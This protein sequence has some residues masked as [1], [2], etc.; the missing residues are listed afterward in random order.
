HWGTGRWSRFHWDLP[1]YGQ[2]KFG[3]GAKASALIQPPVLA[4]AV[5][6]V[7][8][9]SQD[10]DFLRETL[11][12]VRRYYL[13]LHDQRDPDGDGLISVISPYETGM[14]QLP[15]YDRVLGAKNPSSLEM[16]FRDRL[17]DLNNLVLGRN[18]NLDAI[19]RRDA[20]NVEDVM[21]NCIYAQGLRD[22]SELCA[23]AGDETAA[24]GFRNMAGRVEQAV[25][26]KC[27]D[28][29]DGAFWSLGT[30]REQ[31]LKVLTVSS[32]FPVLLSSIDRKR[33][34]ELASV[35]ANPSTFGLPYPLPSVAKN[36]PAFRPNRSFV[37]W[38]G[39]TW[40]NINWFIAKGLRSRGLLE[41]SNSLSK[42]TV[43]M[44]AAGGF[45]EFYNPI[46]GQG[47]GARNFGWSTLVVDMP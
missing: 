46:T 17:L 34:G 45:R 18:Y 38:R 2:S 5:L 29:K 22:V 24:G 10:K 16:H 47:L 32:L 43:E 42:R 6:R 40:V 41:L 19:F 25:L 44:V 27:Y 14:D 4:Q 13:W 12:A 31:A 21:M 35:I 39:A 33:L 3:F 23:L 28:P 7:V 20:F 30:R 9:A 11:D 1:A 36:E 15:A 37:I 8:E 26:S